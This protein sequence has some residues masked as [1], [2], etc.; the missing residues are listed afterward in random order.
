MMWYDGIVLAIVVIAT[1]RGAMKGFVWQLASIAALVACFAFAETASVAVAP[2][3]SVAP[4]LN[5]WIAMLGLYVL[6]V[7]VTFLI[8]RSLREWIEKAKFVEFDRHLGLLFGFLKGVTFCLMMTFFAVTLSETAR[9]HVFESRSGYVA[10]IIM[11]RLHPVMPAELHDVLEPFIHRLDRSDMDLQHSDHHA[12]HRGDGDHHSPSE[13]EH[14][15]VNHQANT[16]QDGGSNSDGRTLPSAY[17]LRDDVRHFPKS[18]ESRSDN[19]DP[20]IAPKG[21]VNLLREISGIFTTFPA[22]RT[23]IVEDIQKATAGI[24]DQVVLAVLRDWRSDLQDLGP[25]PDPDTDGDT[26]LD[27]RIRRQ[28]QAAGIPLTSLS[29]AVQDRLSETP[30]R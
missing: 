28:L 2:Y 24:P 26:Q 10:A 9:A 3:I 4:P 16:G 27:V 23:G 15:H 21:V 6:C 18:P 1:V 20:V 19:R 17:Y 22:G 7:L 25:D 8:A 14:E 29:R 13:A 5:R 11:D 30:P 12:S